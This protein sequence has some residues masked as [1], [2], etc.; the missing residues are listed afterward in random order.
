MVEVINVTE[1]S[2]CH[3]AIVKPIVTSRL[4]TLWESILHS[5]VDKL[6]CI[7]S[8]TQAV[9]FCHLSCL[10]REKYIGP[11]LKNCAAD[12][13]LSWTY[14]HR[15]PVTHMPWKIFTPIIVPLC[16]SIFKLET[17]TGQTEGKTGP[18]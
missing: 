8:E 4:R 14:W 10:N 1:L 18:W 16:L 17:C 2:G 13:L 6:Y 7:V 9:T 12:R 11:V 3:N 5:D 15:L